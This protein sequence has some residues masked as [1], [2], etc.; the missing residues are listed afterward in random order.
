MKCVNKI[1]YYGGTAIGNRIGNLSLLEECE[2]NLKN[3]QVVYSV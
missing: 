3:W 1:E 2:L